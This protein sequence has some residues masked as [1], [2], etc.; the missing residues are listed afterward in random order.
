MQYNIYTMINNNFIVIKAINLESVKELKLIMK[1]K[2]LLQ[3]KKEMAVILKCKED[4]DIEE[5]LLLPNLSLKFSFSSL[6]K[7]YEDYL[8]II[9]VT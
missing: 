4:N 7:S 2:I 8:K 1:T 5:T 9:L 3:S 6:N